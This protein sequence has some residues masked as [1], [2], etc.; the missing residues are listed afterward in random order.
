MNVKRLFPI[1]VLML[2]AVLA[3]NFPGCSPAAHTD[4]LHVT[5]VNVYPKSGSDRFTVTVTIKAQW[6]NVG[7]SLVCYILTSG[8]KQ[9][10]YNQKLNVGYAYLLTTTRSFSISYK[11]PGTYSVFCSIT[12]NNGGLQ[13]LSDEFTVTSSNSANP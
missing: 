7:H 3:C 9:T 6:V 13:P 10:V 12:P 4:D 2:L 1:F 8:K 5:S 11:V